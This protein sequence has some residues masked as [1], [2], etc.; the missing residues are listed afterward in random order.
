MRLGNPL[1]AN[2]ESKDAKHKQGVGLRIATGACQVHPNIW[3]G[4]GV[5]SQM[6]T[7]GEKWLPP[8]WTVLVSNPTLLK[9][10]D[11]KVSNACSMN[12]V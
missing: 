8:L 1:R 3:E 5:A 4:V 10:N 6:G 12:R 7:R 11:L 9:T 2:H